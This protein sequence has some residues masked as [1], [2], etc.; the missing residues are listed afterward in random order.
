MNPTTPYMNGPMGTYPISP[1]ICNGYNQMNQM[2]YCGTAP[3]PPAGLPLSASQMTYQSTMGNQ[4]MNQGLMMSN[5]SAFP[6]APNYYET[7]IATSMS[8]YR[9][10]MINTAVPPIPTIGMNYNQ[11]MVV[12]SNSRVLINQ[13]NS[14]SRVLI[15]GGGNSNSRI[16][17][18]PPIYNKAVIPQKQ[19]QSRIEYIPY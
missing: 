19:S 10:N 6:M 7:G 18:A 13:T 5:V 9:P 17:I 12:N 1:A 8:N 3:L 2:G 11:G 15:G 4:M 16:I 14:N